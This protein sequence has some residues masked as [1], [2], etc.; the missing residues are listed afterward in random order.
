MISGVAD[1]FVA[2]TT[3]SVGV[4]NCAHYRAEE[5]FTPPSPNAKLPLS[6]TLLAPSPASNQGE[7]F[8]K[9]TYR[10]E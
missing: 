10:E 4:I 3:N 2:H 7:N 8:G 5:N 6:V 1:D 9:K